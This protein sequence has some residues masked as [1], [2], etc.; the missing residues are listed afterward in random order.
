M[1][2]NPH[3]SCVQGYVHF[4]DEKSEF[5]RDYDLFKA[6]QLGMPRSSLHTFFPP[7]Q[8]GEEEKKPVL[9]FV[10]RSMGSHERT[11]KKVRV[12]F[13]SHHDL[14]SPSRLPG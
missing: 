4:T 8:P 6:T 2:C 5:Q 10:L 12:V 11:R 3:S 1:I 9:D 7:L 14:F 13:W